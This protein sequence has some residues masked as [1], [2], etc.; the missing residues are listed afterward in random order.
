LNGHRSSTV[1]LTRPCTICCPTS[2]FQM[3]AA[4]TP[5]TS[6]QT[7]IPL[8]RRDLLML[9]YPPPLP[10]HHHPQDCHGYHRHRCPNHQLPALFCLMRSKSVKTSEQLESP[11]SGLTCPTTRSDTIGRSALWTVCHPIDGAPANAQES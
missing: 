1:S 8:M 11:D 3:S 2:H 4:R 9:H 7:H 6:A 10:P 5:F